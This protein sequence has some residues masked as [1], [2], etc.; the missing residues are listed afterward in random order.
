MNS[1]L[2]STSESNRSFRPI[3]ASS[4]EKREGGTRRS[5]T[6][7]GATATSADRAKL[8]SE[9][10][11]HLSGPIVSFAEQNIWP[12]H[13]QPESF[14]PPREVIRCRLTRPQAETNS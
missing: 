2:D 12:V 11:L 1:M 13:L 9:R 10:F 8:R 6:T 14:G 7:S 4:G 5:L 3:A